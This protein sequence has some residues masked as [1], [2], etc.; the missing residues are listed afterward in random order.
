MAYKKLS[1]QIQ[2]LSNPQ[3]SD[4]FVKQF[5]EAVREG[6]FDATYLPERFTMPKAFSRRGAEGSYQ[7]DTKDMLFEVTPAF[8]QWFEQTNN[9]LGAS[10]R[11]GTVKPTAEN[12]EAGL[13]DFRA[14]AEETRRKM[15]A[16]Y[17]KGQ[18][19]G[20]SRA[21][22]TKGGGTKS[23]SSAKAK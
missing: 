18:A 20:K 15:Q 6:Q 4:A 13:V 23:K 17:E 16:S 22:N 9:E 12:I 7:R 10:R 19:L 5:R 8:E 1:E 14:L 11:T 21:R 2:E 3:R